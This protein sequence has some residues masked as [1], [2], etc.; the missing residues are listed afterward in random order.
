V[1]TI[2]GHVFFLPN[3]TPDRIADIILE[4]VSEAR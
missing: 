1:V 3:E 4:A 2:P